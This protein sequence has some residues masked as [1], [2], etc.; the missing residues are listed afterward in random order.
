MTEVLSEPNAEGELLWPYDTSAIKEPPSGLLISTADSKAMVVRGA[1]LARDAVA[2]VIGP[3]GLSVALSQTFGATRQSQQGLQIVRGI[4]SPNTLEEKGIEQLRLAAASIYDAAGDCTKLVCILCSGLIAA[5]QAL[6]EKGF[7]TKDVTASLDRTVAR[8][9]EHLA[10][11]ARPLAGKQ[12]LDVAVT[13]ARGDAELGRLVVDGLS[14]AGQHGVITIE[15]SHDGQHRLD[16]QEG[17]RFDKGYLSDRFVTDPDKLEC[18]LEDCLILFHQAPIVSMKDLL[19][20]LEQVARSDK[21]LLV[22]ADRVEGEALSTLAVNKLRGILRCAAVKAPGFADRRKA[23]L[24]DAAVITGGVFFSDE[25]GIPLTNVCIDNLGHAEKVVVGEHATTI[26]GGGGSTEKIQNRIRTIRT[27][28][29]TSQSAVDKEKLQER[30]A[31]L[32]GGLAAVKVGGLSENDTAINF[33]KATSALHSAR[34]ATEQGIVVG[35][36]AALSQ[37]AALID[38]QAENGELDKAAASL[39]AAVLRE[40]I[41][42]LIQTAGKS[43]THVLAEIAKS[44][45]SKC[46]FNAQTSEIEDLEAAGVLDAVAPIRESLSLAFSHARFVLETAAW[47]ISVSEPEK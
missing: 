35:G 5:G 17:L 46:G 20:L 10:Q 39:V 1:Q 47:D 33:Y 27:Q 3:R 12:L 32:A 38:A 15:L 37:T 45:S 34:S 6:I 26:I 21:S 13:A 30:L 18:V 11:A 16:V 29:S 43:P 8:A 2:A 22:V 14:R 24:E 19:P 40:P 31:I 42:L 28:I 7:H 25:L 36:G 41:Q 23:L 9:R 4:K 44:A